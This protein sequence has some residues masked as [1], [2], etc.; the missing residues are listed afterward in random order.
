LG[1]ITKAASYG[2]HGPAT[3]EMFQDPWLR[4]MTEE[5]KVGKTETLLLM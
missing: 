4:Q 2:G 3:V 5:S 1:I